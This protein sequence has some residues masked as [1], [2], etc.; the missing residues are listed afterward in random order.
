MNQTERRIPLRL[1]YKMPEALQRVLQS[2]Q[3]SV[4]PYALLLF[5]DLAATSFLCEHVKR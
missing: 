4:E 5:S 3:T 2:L 1:G